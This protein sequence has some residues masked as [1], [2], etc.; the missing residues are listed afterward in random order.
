[1]GTT[2]FDGLPFEVVYLCEEPDCSSAATATLENE[3]RLCNRHAGC[4]E[5]SR[6]PAPSAAPTAVYAKPEPSV[7][8]RPGNKRQTTLQSFCKP[9]PSASPAVAAIRSAAIALPIAKTQPLLLKC[10][11]QTKSN[12]A[13]QTKPSH[14][15]STGKN[16]KVVSDGASEPQQTQVVGISS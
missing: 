7:S 10:T 8:A 14:A 1:M 4:A 3:M 16:R 12:Q 6:N 9:G 2:H 5:L 13:R 15:T 11:R